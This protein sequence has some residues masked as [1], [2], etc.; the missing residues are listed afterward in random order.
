MLWSFCVHASKSR[1]VRSRSTRITHILDLNSFCQA[2]FPTLQ[3]LYPRQLLM[4]AP[5]FPHLWPHRRWSFCEK[6]CRADKRKD[7]CFS[8]RAPGCWGILWICLRASARV[9]WGQVRCNAGR[10]WPQ[11][12]PERPTG[13]R[14]R[15]TPRVLTVEKQQNGR[16]SG[17]S[18][19]GYTQRGHLIQQSHSAYRPKSGL[20]CPHKNVR[21]S[22][23]SIFHTS[24]KVDTTQMAIHWGTDKQD[25][26]YPSKG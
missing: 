12:W 5:T 22:V 20:T 7:Q 24:W 11:E 10:H 17:S 6:F 2:V 26:V 14:K 16:Q 18:S 1:T 13:M 4:G 8:N 19:K 3:H 25:V 15:K 21:V 23:H 9:R